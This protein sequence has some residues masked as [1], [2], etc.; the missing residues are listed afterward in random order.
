MIDQSVVDAFQR[1]GFVVV[2]NLLSDVE[3]SRYEAAVTQAVAHRKRKDT[4]K[5]EEK[6]PYEQS[7]LQCMNL[8][9]DFPEVRPLTFHQG[10]AEVAAQL[11][12]ANALRLWHDQA[13]YKEAGG[14]ITDTHQDLPYWAMAE[15]DALTAWIPFQGSTIQSGCMGFIPGSHKLGLRKLVNIFRAGSEDLEEQANELKIQDPVYVE[16]PRGAVSFHHGLTAHDAKPNLTEKNRPV[17]TMI[18][19]RDGMTRSERGQHYV[20]DRAGIKP[21]EKIASEVTPIAWPR[22][23][24]PPAPAPMELSAMMKASGAFPVVDR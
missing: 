2:D 10:I 21:G 23:D 6:T 12:G 7:F 22:A 11:I 1:D 18:F 24:L 3:I 5:L 15:T 17:H 8:W 4:R 19:F 13:L 9:E 14:R 16:V 20:V